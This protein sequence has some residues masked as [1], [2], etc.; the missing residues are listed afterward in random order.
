MTYDKEAYTITTFKMTTELHNKI[1]KFNQTH[2]N[3]KI[4]VSGTC[5]EAVEQKLIL[6]TKQEK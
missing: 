6:R 4:N 3:D 2:P 1:K 5:R